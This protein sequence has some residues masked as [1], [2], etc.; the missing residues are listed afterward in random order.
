MGIGGVVRHE[1]CA[2]K[3]CCAEQ[4]NQFFCI[5]YLYLIL[6]IEIGCK[7]TAFC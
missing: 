1:W 5:H 3:K 6:T 4:E 7:D 2:S